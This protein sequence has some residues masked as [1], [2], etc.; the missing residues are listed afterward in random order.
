MLKDY[1]ITADERKTHL[2]LNAFF[3]KQLSLDCEDILFPKE[4]KKN[5]NMRIKLPCNAFLFRMQIT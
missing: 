4:K 3:V 1:V 2:P 5:N